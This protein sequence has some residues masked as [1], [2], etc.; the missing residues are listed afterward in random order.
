MHMLMSNGSIWGASWR[1]RTCGGIS[2]IDPSACLQVPSWRGHNVDAAV[3][4]PVSPD[5]ERAHVHKLLLDCNVYLE[6]C[7]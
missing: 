5:F 4:L 7:F 3:V 1:S 2:E 6:I